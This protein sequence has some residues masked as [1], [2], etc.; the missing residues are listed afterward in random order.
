MLRQQRE[1]LANIADKAHIQH[2]VGFVHDEH[3]D[4]RQIQR[5][6][7]HVIQQTPRRRH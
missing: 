4:F 5:A 1:N 2:A 3:L 7:L 6:L